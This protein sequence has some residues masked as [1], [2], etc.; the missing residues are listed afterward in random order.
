MSVLQDLLTQHQTAF[1]QE[2]VGE[3]MPILFDRRGRK[4]NQIVGCSPFMQPVHVKASNEYFGQI[5]DVNLLTAT[6]NSLS[7]E[8]FLNDKSPQN[9]CNISFGAERNFV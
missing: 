3:I 8:I 7:G 1:N 5:V 6:S 4:T 2:S 9:L